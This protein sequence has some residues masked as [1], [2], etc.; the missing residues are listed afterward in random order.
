MGALRVD[1]IRSLGLLS[2]NYANLAS[3]RAR[4]ILMHYDQIPKQHQGKVAMT[5]G[6]LRSILIG[7]G[8]GMS[9]RLSSKDIRQ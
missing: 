6:R 4:T 7:I 1:P 3:R 8:V 2:P 9:H 5:A